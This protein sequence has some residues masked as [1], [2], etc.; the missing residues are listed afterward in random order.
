[1]KTKLKFITAFTISLLLVFISIGAVSV[2][3]NESDPI[4]LKVMAKGPEFYD[5]TT[6]VTI[7]AE[8]TFGEPNLGKVEFHHKTYVGDEKV[9]A[10]KG[11]L[12]DGI[13]DVWPSWDDALSG[14]KFFNLWFIHGYGR[15]K[16][17]I[18]PYL[19]AY[20]GC[21]VCPPGWFLNPDNEWVWGNGWAWAA[22]IVGGVEPNWKW[23][24]RATNITM[25]KEIVP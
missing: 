8:I 18:G 6:I 14:S 22:I 3:A 13:V 24:G 19:E 16:Y 4:K 10:L 12:S 7:I 11:K 1:M 25:Y 5:E 21:I 2:R 17:Q 23:E 9:W 20:V 15:A